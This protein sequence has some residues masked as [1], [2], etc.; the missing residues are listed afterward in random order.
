MNYKRFED[1]RVWQDAV[2]FAVSIFDLTEDSGFRN[3]GDIASQVQR[4]GLSVSTTSQNSDIRG[5]RHL[6][7]SSREHYRQRKRAD[8]FMEKLKAMNEEAARKRSN[9]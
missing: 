5:Q 8:E 1:V 2:A 3:R 6:T 4:A 7:E 9:E